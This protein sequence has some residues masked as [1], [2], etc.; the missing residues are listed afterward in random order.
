MAE[1]NVDYAHFRFV[2]GTDA[3]PE[4]DFVVDGTYKRAVG[5]DGNFVREGYGL[6]LGVLRIAGYVTF[7]SSTTPIDEESVHVRWAFTAPLAN[8]PRPSA[9]PPTSFCDG[10]SQDIPIWENKVYR[11]ARCSPGPS[12]R[13]SNTAAGPGSSTPTTRGPARSTTPRP[14]RG[15]E[16]GSRVG[17]DRGCRPRGGGPTIPSHRGRE[18]G[19]DTTPVLQETEVYCWEGPRRA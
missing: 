14:D 8:G 2:H 6:G 16:V 9:R 10:V 18:G 11:R 12:G 7:L 3:I 19:M 17:I 5:M 1:N 4:D 15:R 13:S